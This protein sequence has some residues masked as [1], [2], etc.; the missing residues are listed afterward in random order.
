MGLTDGG[1]QRTERGIALCLEYLFAQKN[2]IRSVAFAVS[3]RSTYETHTQHRVVSHGFVREV[4]IQCLFMSV[5]EWSIAQSCTMEGICWENGMHAAFCAV[6]A[7]LFY[8]GYRPAVH[9]L[10]C[11]TSGAEC[12]TTSTLAARSS[13]E[14][15]TRSCSLWIRGCCD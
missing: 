12:A 11:D 7:S 5:F 8:E 1:R 6:L 3:L 14:C 10:L 4:S 15:R 9:L 2:N 13:W